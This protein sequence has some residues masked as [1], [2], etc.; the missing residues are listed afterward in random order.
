MT[1]WPSSVAL[2]NNVDVK[3]LPTG[4]PDVSAQLIAAK[5]NSTAPGFSVTVIA[6]FGVT[7]R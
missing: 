7:L 2:F 5:E 6:V 1:A 4:L 3:V